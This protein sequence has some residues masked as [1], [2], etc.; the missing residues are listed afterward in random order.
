MDTSAK[1]GVIEK[2]GMKNAADHELFVTRWAAQAATVL[3]PGLTLHKIKGAMCLNTQEYIMVSGSG[4]VACYVLAS[5]VKAKLLKK[6]LLKLQPPKI[7]EL[8]GA[9]EEDLQPATPQEVAKATPKTG[10]A[11]SCEDDSYKKNATA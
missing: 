9:Q 7:D 4:G 8:Q 5:K 3:P 1:T 2:L 6:K 10:E 11:E